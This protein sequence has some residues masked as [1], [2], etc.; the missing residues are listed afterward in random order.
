MKLVCFNV[1]E[2]GRNFGRKQVTCGHVLMTGLVE[3]R[4]IDIQCP[5]CGAKGNEA[6]GVGD[7]WNGESNSS[8]DY[9]YAPL[10]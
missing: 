7:D 10:S 3:Y 9:L 4:G 8:V 2:P 5:R 6:D 1:I